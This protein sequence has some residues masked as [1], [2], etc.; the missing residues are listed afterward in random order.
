MLLRP[1][2]ILGGRH[3]IKLLPLID[4]DQQAVR[5]FQRGAEAPVDDARK[6]PR[7]AGAIKV[8]LFFEM[9][10]D[11]GRAGAFRNGCE[12]FGERP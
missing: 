3:G 5:L 1:F 12:H 4:V 11:L 8:R 9:R 7:V 6:G 2:P 10:V